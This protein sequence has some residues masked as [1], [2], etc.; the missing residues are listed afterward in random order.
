MPCPL[1]GAV[2]SGTAVAVTAISA[3]ASVG[4]FFGSS[5]FVIAVVVDCSVRTCDCCFYGV[6]LANDSCFVLSF[7]QA[8]SI[9]FYHGHL[10]SLMVIQR[11]VAVMFSPVS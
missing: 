3:S 10:H 4:Y 7:S 2:L 1:V 11:A 8:V 5:V 6:L 9:A